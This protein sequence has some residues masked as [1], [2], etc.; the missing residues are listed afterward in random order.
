MHYRLPGRASRNRQATPLIGLLPHVSLIIGFQ[1][2][3]Y[4]PF[5]SQPLWLFHS[6]PLNSQPHPGLFLTFKPD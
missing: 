6:L 3:D 4:S 5:P 1:T 2:L